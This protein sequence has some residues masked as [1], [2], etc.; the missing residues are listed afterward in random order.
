MGHTRPRYNFSKE[1]LSL[2]VIEEIIRNLSSS[3][4]YGRLFH[5]G[6]K[7]RILAIKMKIVHILGYCFLYIYLRV[8]VPLEVFNGNYLFQLS[9]YSGHQHWNNHSSLGEWASKSTTT[10]RNKFWPV[11]KK[12]SSHS[13][14][15][16][17]SQASHNIL[18]FC[19]SFRY[20]KEQVSY[21]WFGWGFD[22]DH[23]RNL[24]NIV[25]LVFFS[26]LAFS[27][28]MPFFILCGQVD[29]HILWDM[30]ET[31]QS[32]RKEIVSCVQCM[33]IMEM[34][35]YSRAEKKLFRLCIFATIIN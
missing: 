11:M 34:Y 32:G 19:G 29:F 23:Y 35:H 15:Q 21:P 13:S 25:L 10:H 20:C 24:T 3:L 22:E 8:C 12:N 9:K 5:Q 16:N 2:F 6:L 1:I 31:D 4:W 17:C 18:V 33:R 26:Q 14:H 7:I 28:L 30:N 27:H